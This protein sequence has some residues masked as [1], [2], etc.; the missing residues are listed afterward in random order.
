M[1]LF[2]VAGL[3]VLAGITLIWWFIKAEGGVRFRPG[4]AELISLAAGLSGV[5]LITIFMVLDQDSVTAA[6]AAN[7]LVI[8]GLGLVMLGCLALVRSV[9][10]IEFASPR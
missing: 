9:T 7:S 10:R 4:P 8:L 1:A 5:A 3:A 2:V 6:I